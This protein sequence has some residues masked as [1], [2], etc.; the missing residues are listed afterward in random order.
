LTTS[1][2]A[3]VDGPRSVEAAFTLE[4]VHALAAAADMG[5][6]AISRRWPCRYLL[7]WRRP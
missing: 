1:P 7:A 2:V 6:A 3:R 4:E 5:N